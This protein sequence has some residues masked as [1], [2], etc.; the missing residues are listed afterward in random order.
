[1]PS[2]PPAPRPVTEDEASAL[3]RAREAA[4]AARRDAEAA[5]SRVVSNLRLVTFLA[6]AA[7]A[8]TAVFGRLAGSA[9]LWTGSAAGF[10]A[11]GWLVV[12]HA[13]I[14]D[15]RAWHAALVEVN[16]LGGARL[17]R[18]WGALP[19]PGPPVADTSHPYATDLDLSGRASL[20][21]L[22]DTGTISGR[23]TLV[24]WL[25][26]PAE[27]AAIRERQRAVTALAPSVEVRQALAAHGRLAAAERP[28]DLDAFLA[29]AE[30]PVRPS[31]RPWLMC[32]VWLLTAATWLAIAG[33]F[34]GILPGTLWL[35]PV[36]PSVAL[37]YAYERSTRATF[38]RA[39]GQGRVFRRY[40][41]LF[42][43]VCGLDVDAP[44]VMSCR[45]ALCAPGEA[46]DHMRRLDRLMTLADV[47]YA[48]PL[49]YF[50]VQALTLWDFHVLAAL[51]RW[52][53]TAGP[54]ARRWF[55]ALGTVDAL[56]ALATL[57]HDHP[58]WAM[59]EIVE[60]DGPAVV[61]ARALAHPLL[62]GATRV[63]N[64]VE[65]GPP[66]TVL[67]VTG[68]NMSGKSTL[69]RA[70]GLN[71]VLAQAGG[72]VCAEALALPP[73]HVQTSMRVED[74]LELG[75]SYFMAGLARL[76][77]VVTAA[78]AA[79]V[80]GRPVLYLLDEILQGTNSAE[81][82]VAVERVVARLVATGAVG[83]VTTHD[84]ALAEAPAI[85]A[86][87]ALV[88]FRETV[89][90]GPDGSRMSF[91]YRL[92]PGLATSRNA[93]RLMRM[94]GL[95]D[96]GLKAALRGGFVGERLEDAL[97]ARELEQLA[98]VVGHA[99]ELQPA[100]A[101]AERDVRVD[102]LAQTRAVQVFELRHVQHDARAPA[103]RQGVDLCL[104][105]AVPVVHGETAAHVEHGDVAHLALLDLHGED[106]GKSIDRGANGFTTERRRFTTEGAEGHGGG[107]SGCLAVTL[108]RC[109]AA[110][111][112]PDDILGPGRAAVMTDQTREP[113]AHDTRMTG[114]YIFALVVEAVVI[115][116]LWS[117]SHYFG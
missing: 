7:L 20:L 22:V 1:M 4:A 66:G 6:G 112:I 49:L 10:A 54:H 25:L 100:A 115:A 21:Q 103:L 109:R 67:L 110:T 38:D 62:P 13:R 16:R 85:A 78:G 14:E 50:I 35:A 53:R 39:F 82:L 2:D 84:L 96:A 94:M 61:R 17:A 89:T 27:P 18:D 23:A 3:Y 45:D 15:R 68:S 72:P 98:Q 63:A 9:L 88:H 83:A 5:R 70:V 12:R 40:A 8:G 75:V 97:Q 43:L 65:V 117:F 56:A 105:Q 113:D 30:S 52:Q 42:A 71:V 87:A 28:H 11:F 102:D 29:W 36:L 92:R 90:D 86:V 59:P 106:S 33:G 55:D 99:D 34:A 91:D 114:T 95:E 60:R 107:Y 41:S 111:A 77:A 93:L 57:A 32:T 24:G 81:R 76:K 31:V 108:S 64:D 51:E 47:R 44:L 79:R 116:A 101:P 26:A 74:S 19:S 104:E 46:A 73:L 69:L 80:G 48:M 37:T 58:G